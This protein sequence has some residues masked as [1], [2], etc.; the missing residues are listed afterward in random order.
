M[1]VKRVPADKSLL[2]TLHFSNTL[3]AHTSSFLKQLAIVLRV[4]IKGLSSA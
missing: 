3:A 2:F 1:S 4:G